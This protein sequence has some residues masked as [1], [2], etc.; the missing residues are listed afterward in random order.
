MTNEEYFEVSPQPKETCPI[1]DELIYDIDVIL[2]TIKNY[3]KADEEELLNMVDTIDSYIWSFTDRL[4]EIR[5]N[6][7]LIRKWGQEWKDIVVKNKDK[8]II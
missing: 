1:I 2:D 5:R 3:S 6:A 7:E 8:I 4:E